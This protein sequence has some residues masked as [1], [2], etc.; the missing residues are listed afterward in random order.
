LERTL[1]ESV[2][3]LLQV[4]NDVG[5]AFADPVQLESALT[6]LAI[7]ARDAMPMGGT[8][9]I[10]AAVQHLD[11]CAENAEVVPGDYV[12]LAVS[13]TGA[14]MAPEVLNRVFEP[15]FTTKGA[16]G[17]G[18]GLSMVYGFAKQSGGHVRISSE[19]GRGT[20]VR[21]YLPRAAQGKVGNETRERSSG[22]AVGQGETVLL[23]EDN[24]DVRRLGAMHLTDLGYRVREAENGT[25]ALQML[26]RDDDIDLLF[27]D[28]VM[29]GG[30]SGIDL[31][32]QARELRPQ[33]RVL[34]TSGFARTTTLPASMTDTVNFLPK[35][36]RKT[37]L[38]EKVRGALDTPPSSKAA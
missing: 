18:L 11:D 22:P 10:E 23:V 1:G 14:G 31:E 12:M 2:T 34:F 15:F 29:P 17:S 4:A 9:T 30:V 32:R 38:A 28:I 24:E 33:L 7:N 3:I 5:P 26:V 13:D 37:E 21:L 19:L 36:Y 20:S 35:P 16:K 6:N 27:T 25:K 8:L